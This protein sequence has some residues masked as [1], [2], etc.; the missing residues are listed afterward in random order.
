MQGRRHSKE[1]MEII[2]NLQLASKK[3]ASFV[4]QLHGN[5]VASSS[6]TKRWIN[7]VPVTPGLIFPSLDLIEKAATED[8]FGRDYCLTVDEMAMKKNVR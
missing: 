7:K 6:T 8:I 3:G 5:A 1:A 2:C 4:R